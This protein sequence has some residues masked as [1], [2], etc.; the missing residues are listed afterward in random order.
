LYEGIYENRIVYICEECAEKEG[1][2]LLKRPTPEQLEKIDKVDSV[3]E[4]L[5]KISGFDKKNASQDHLITS[6]NLA[7][8][9][10]PEK[11]QEHEDLVENYYWKIQIARRRKKLSLSQLSE[12]TNIPVELLEAVEKGQLPENFEKI[13]MVLE[14]VL[15]IRIFKRHSEKLIFHLPEKKPEQKEKEIIEQTKEKIKE[16]EKREEEKLKEKKKIIEQIAAGKFDFS[17]RENLQDITLND[18]IE[19][20]KQRER[21]EMLGDDLEIDEQ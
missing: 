21:E 16:Q 20:K 12:K 4:R 19:L 1:V 5:N 14:E 13:M 15:G 7:K 8:L 17:K 11:R 3:K 6:E 2:P 9:N 10:I 18:L